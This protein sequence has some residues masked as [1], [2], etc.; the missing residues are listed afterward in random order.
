[1]S[2]QQNSN[3]LQ[4]KPN[5]HPT[6]IIILTTGGTIEKT[7]D[8]NDG[9]LINRYSV[10]ESKVLSR[11]RLPYTEVEVRPV[12]AKDS[13]YMDDKDREQL[14]RVLEQFIPELLPIVILH[15]TDTVD[16]SARYCQQSLSKIEV[17]IIFTGAMRPLELEDSD[18]FQNIVEAIFAAQL[19]PAGVYLSFHG[20]IFAAS[21]FKKNRKLGTFEW[22]DAS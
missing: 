7:Y 3:W 5:N 1:M 20:R 19:L 6:K 14:V 12:L 13:L 16:Q 22:D 9:L 11:L 18:A 17:P 8:E 4:L 21:H 2:G 15:G 10:V